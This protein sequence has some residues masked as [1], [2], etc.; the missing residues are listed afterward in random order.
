MERIL[1]WRHL[2]ALVFV[3]LV[4][5]VTLAG[6]ALGGSG[7]GNKKTIKRITAQQVNRLAPG[8][9]VAHAGSADNAGNAA[10]AANAEMVGGAHVCSGTV[11]VPA[12][13]E[14][15]PLC[16]TGPLIV[17]AHCS[18]G[19]STTE[20]RIE[21]SSSQPN[22]WV[23]GTASDGSTA[24]AI[25]RA[26]LVSPETVVDATDSSTAGTT[27]AGGGASLSVG[28]ADGSSI[29]GTFSVRADHTGATQGTCFATS[30]ATSR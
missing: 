23:F 22:S 25:G 6:V 21:V 12:D 7:Q 13:A 16:A 4:L 28:A 24:S 14:N 19:T 27:G 8:L 26:F 30:G 15:H 17:S 2:P 11:N 10:D 9:S 29:S 5:V 3:V 20:A 18:H 1:R